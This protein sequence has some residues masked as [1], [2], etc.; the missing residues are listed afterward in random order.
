LVQRIR[1]W[2][3]GISVA[4]VIAATALL[5]YALADGGPLSA[6]YVLSGA[7]GICGVTAVV[8]IAYRLQPVAGFIGIG[9]L[10][11]ALI[12]LAAGVARI[13]GQSPF[14]A[15]PFDFVACLLLGATAVALFHAPPRAIVL[16]AVVGV[17]AFGVAWE[18]AMTFLVSVFPAH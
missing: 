9:G 2:H 17:V 3:T 18:G 4:A 7:A 5:S 13:S 16:G 6:R 10:A 11:A 8:A 1:A 15:L 12:E 14:L